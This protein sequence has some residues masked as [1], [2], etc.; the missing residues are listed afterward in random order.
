MRSEGMEMKK[1][2]GE[3]QDE[4]SFYSNCHNWFTGICCMVPAS[5]EITW[6]IRE[7][8]IG[9]NYGAGDYLFLAAVYFIFIHAQ[10]KKS[11]LP[12]NIPIYPIFHRPA[13]WLFIDT[14]L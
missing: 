14:G 12:E 10:D 4:K 11:A 6:Q 1:Y 9:G 8:I 2:F 3:Q 7:T 13:C 5:I